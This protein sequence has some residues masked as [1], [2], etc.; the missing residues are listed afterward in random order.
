M[1]ENHPEIATDIYYGLE[2]VQSTIE[3]SV[4][5]L[6]SDMHIAIDNE[7]N[8]DNLSD[9]LK[10]SKELLKEIN[11]YLQELAFIENTFQKTM[12]F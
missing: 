6:K 10:L 3:D 9:M 11:N 2:M 8:Y 4:K 1:A 12:R 5:K 7:D